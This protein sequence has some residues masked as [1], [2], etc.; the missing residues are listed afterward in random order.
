MCP[1]N[2]FEIPGNGNPGNPNH[3]ELSYMGGDSGNIV[4]S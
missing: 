4:Y 2:P 1:I 3:G